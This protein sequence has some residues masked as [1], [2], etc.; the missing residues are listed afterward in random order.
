MIDR[1]KILSIHAKS[2]PISGSVKLNTI[3]Q[4]T[5][6]FTGADLENLLNEA[7]L[8]AT[9]RKKQI[10]E[11]D[12]VDDAHDKILL[13]LERKSLILTGKERETVAYHEAGHAVMAAF[14]PNA[15]PVHKVTIIPR[16]RSMG[17]TQQHPEGDKYLFNREYIL[18]RIAVTLGGRVAE[19]RH[20][21][22]ITSGA[23]NDL[24]Q[25]TQLARK[26]VLDWGMSEK[27]GNISLGS[28]REH[29]F[30][31]EDI[32]TRRDFSEATA[33]EIDIEIKL[34]LDEA[35]EQATKLLSEKENDIIKVANGLLEK[36]ALLSEDIKE[37]LGLESEKSDDSKT[38]E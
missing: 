37:L 12:D 28:E 23:E 38:E 1:E 27:L 16:D 20:M 35:Y 10:I 21:G 24:R 14:L 30:L 3:A 13:G 6:G 32:A 15:E 8:L 34:I 9:R 17:V 25:A 31:G 4:V 7:A 5:P 29:V 26:M 11:R 2:K 22:T 18:D 19:K 36:E 33:R